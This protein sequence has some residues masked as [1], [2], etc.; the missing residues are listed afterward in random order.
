MYKEVGIN[1][2]YEIPFTLVYSLFTLLVFLQVGSRDLIEVIISGAVQIID[3]ESYR[4]G[5]A[6]EQV[7]MHPLV[8]RSLEKVVIV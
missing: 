3:H 6:L 2:T 1:P 5:F 4:V 7:I 8:D